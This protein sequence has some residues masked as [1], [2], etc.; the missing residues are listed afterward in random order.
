MKDN[1]VTIHK[2][3]RCNFRLHG[4]LLFWVMRLAGVA[5]ADSVVKNGR[6]V[7]K[8]DRLPLEEPGHEKNN[9]SG[10]S[11]LRIGWDVRLY[12]DHRRRLNLEAR[13]NAGARG[14]DL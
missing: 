9:N 13:R 12:E 5:G 14:G 4:I 1:T 10:C 6:F 2:L 3:R 8:I 11:H 7:V